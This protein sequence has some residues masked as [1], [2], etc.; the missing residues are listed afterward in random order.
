MKKN[1]RKLGALVIVLAAVACQ[2]ELIPFG[3]SPAGSDSAAGLSP[4]NEVPAVTN[5]TGSGG[6]IS[7]GIVFDT[8][9]SNLQLAIGYGSAAGFTDLTGAGTGITLNGPATSL[10]NAGVIFD[11]TPFNFPASNPL[12]GGIVFANVTVSSN[13]VADLLNGLDYI[14]VETSSN[15]N[16]E[17][18]GQ[19]IPQVPVLSC[20][21]PATIQCGTPYVGV[22]TVR[23]PEGLATSVVWFLNGVA[24]Q[25][26]R[27]AAGSSI[28]NNTAHF[29][30]DLP[31]GTNLVEVVAT[32]SANLSATCSTMVIVV[33][34]IPPVITAASASPNQLWPP[35]HNMVTITVNAV[36]ADNCGLAPWKIIS[37]QSN[38][39]VNMIGSGNTSPDWQILGPHT[40]ALRAE[41]SGTGSGRIYTI[42]IQAKDASGNLSSTRDVTVTVP[43]SMGKG[44]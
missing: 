24:V 31:L 13:A 8:E 7:G 10:Q 11:L 20:P 27:I 22:A 30:A 6:V 39:A 3:I 26:N 37:V 4:A 16:G 36:V 12:H 25:T 5:S 21:E 34:T 2:A 18:R 28:T 19:I 9:T 43:K 38:E 32:D 1:I 44:R 17:I 23:D 15:T 35:N 42:T 41:R 14:N 33:D 40:V 29:D